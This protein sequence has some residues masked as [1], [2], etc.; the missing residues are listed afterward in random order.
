[1]PLGP[2]TQIFP[3]GG[4]PYNIND[5]PCGVGSQNPLL[6]L[7]A[8]SHTTGGVWVQETYDLSAFAGSVIRIRFHVGWDCGNCAPV[9]DEGWHI[10]DVL[11][12]VPTLEYD[13]HNVLFDC[14]NFDGIVDPGETIDLE[15]TLENV[16]TFDTCNI[17]GTLST[18]TPGI[19]IPVNTAF[20]GNI[21]MGGF[22]TSFPP[23]FQ[24]VVAP[25]VP[26]GTTI[27]FTLDLAFDDCFAT[28]YTATSTF[29]VQVGFVAPS[30]PLLSTDFNPL[31]LGWTVINGGSSI[32]TWDNFDPC[33]RGSFPPLYM[34]CDNN[35]PL[36]G[37]TMDEELITPLIN[38]VGM[39]TVT[40]R[41]DHDL[42]YAF[43]GEMVE[44]DVMSAKTGWVWV[45]VAQYTNSTGGP[46]SEFIDITAQAAGAPDVQIRW[47]YY[48][49]LNAGYWGVDNVFVAGTPP[50]VCNPIACG[51]HLLYEGH[52]ILMD[53]GNFNG[54]V[55]PG[56]TIDLDVTV[57][58]FGNNDAFNVNGTLST[59]T[60]GVTI[61][62][63]VAWV[64]NIPTGSS[65]SLAPFQFVVDPSVPCGTFINF[66]LDLTYDDGFTPYSNSV[67]FVVQ[68][69]NGA[70][71]FADDMEGGDNGWTHYLISSDPFAIPPVT[72]GWEQSTMRSSSNSTSWWSGTLDGPWHTSALETPDIDLTKVGGAVLSFNHWYDFGECGVIGDEYDGA[73]V[74]VSVGGG[75][76]NQIFPLGGY[77][78]TLVFCGNPLD[79]FAAYA[80]DSACVF[81]PQAFDLTPFAGNVIRIRFRVGASAWCNCNYPLEGWY[82]DDVVIGTVPPACAPAAC[83]PYLQYDSEV[84]TDCGN[85]DGVVDPGET[86]TVSLTV[87]NTGSEGA[88]NVSG[89]LS[90]L[91]PGVTITVPTASFPD[92]PVGLTGTSLTPFEFIVDGAVVCGTVIDFTLD[93]TYTD[94]AL[95]PFSNT[96]T[97]PAQ[98][99]SDGPSVPI[100]SEN[101]NLGLPG[102]WT[103]VDNGDN[104]FCAPNC[105]WVNNDPCGRGFF[106]DPY[107][108]ADESCFWVDMDEELITPLIDASGVTKVGIIFEHNFDNG[109]N[110]AIANVDVRSANTGGAWVNVATF[111]ANV[112]GLEIIDITTQAAGAAD[113]QVRWHYV[114]QPSPGWWAIDNV[115]VQTPTPVCNPGCCPLDPAVISSIAPDPVCQGTFQVFTAAA[116]TGG[117]AP[118][119]YS[120]D[121]TDDSTFDAVGQIVGYTYPA[122][123]SYTVRLRVTDSCSLGSQVQETT[124]SVT[125]YENPTAAPVVAPE[126]VCLGTVQ[127]FTANAAL[128]LAPYTYL[129]NFGNG[130]TS[131]AANPVYMYP[132]DGSYV[133]TVTVTD[134]LGC[135]SG[136]VGVATNPVEVY[137]PEAAP[138][139]DAE[140]VC[141]GTAQTF[142]ANASRGSPFG[143]IPIFTDDME[144]G[145]NGWTVSGLWAQISDPATCSP[146]SN[147]ATTSWYFG[148][149]TGLACDYNVASNCTSPSTGFLAVCGELVSPSIG[150]LPAGAVLNFWYRRQTEDFCA[151]YDRTYVEISDDGGFSWA[152]L[153]ELCDESNSWVNSGN[154]DLSAY[155]GA[156]VNIRF[157]VDTGDL[158]LNAF[159]GWM[160]DD[161]LVGEPIYNYLWSFGNGDTSTAENP[162][163]TYPADGSYTVTVT[164]TDSFGCSFG[165][166][167]VATNPVEVYGPE[168]APTVD[169]EPVCIGTVQTFTANASLGLVPYTYMWSF[170]NGDTSTAASPVYT[171]PADGSYTVTLTVT[172]SFGCS[173]GPIGV[174]TNPVEVYGPTAAPVVDAEPVCIGTVQQFTA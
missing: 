126:P 48:N 169:V 40:L 46:V 133:V 91:T 47:H 27:D 120:W 109:A 159:L 90:T 69:G 26:C 150:P 114:S 13:S 54:V 165:P 161:V 23:P 99:G 35:C 30:V 31:P 51:P 97:G 137:G 138:V 92:I 71:V 84:I 93:L 148:Q 171:Y 65:A 52:Q 64:P 94:V 106:F 74:E 19:T 9:G 57:F 29:Q 55:D 89:T 98:V 121:F 85:S 12:H 101:F 108:I 105:T 21:A 58:N 56:E 49:A 100:F 112:I 160:V 76:W 115:S 162:V 142:V 153:W 66:T 15:V 125:V 156:T 102:T 28:P 33:G 34:I 7:D 146:V 38:A 42:L 107:M 41:F 68:V 24:F 157:R 44:V 164:V 129:W 10:D 1:M 43:M 59:T 78:Y 134:S 135:S 63:N 172:D 136:L 17:N 14:G 11:V 144:S 140:P 151:T 39:G 45:N 118:Y 116:A 166:V 143:F 8:Y 60:P 130:D 6:G 152:V 37:Y 73:L 25:G 158:A 82:L 36:G 86:V 110:C 168:A 2:W 149:D 96:I 131:T 20:F 16:G 87:L 75:P 170:G 3:S 67:S 61:P 53:C 32:D 83:G 103:V 22:G 81:E 155:A 147:S 145:I 154:I 141:L 174:A 5:D 167:G 124:A 173:S 127:T 18:G 50:A 139:V 111:T 122:D 77:P 119:T 88:F 72:D 95:N 117:V 4:Y 123:G 128:G 132:A 70:L 104:S 62:M 80:H 113:V 163:Y 79:G